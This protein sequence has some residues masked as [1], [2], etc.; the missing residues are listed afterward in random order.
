MTPENEI[1]KVFAELTSRYDKISFSTINDVLSG[2]IK[3]KGR[4]TEFAQ[5]KTNS[6]RIEEAE[7][8][9]LKYTCVIFTAF[10]GGYT[11][12]ENIA[13]NQQL[14][15]DM[16]E[17][18]LQYRPVTGCYREADWE[19]ANIE[20]CYFVYNEK[21]N[22]DLD[23]FIKAFQLSEKYDQDSFLYKRAGIN[24]T[25][26]L[27]ASTDAG[28]TDL[29]GNIRFAGQLFLYVPDVDAWTDCSDGRFSFQLKGMILIGTNCNKIKIGEGNLFDAESYGADGLVVLRRAN[30]DDLAEYCKN[31][32]GKA[33]L[34]QHVFKKD[35]PSEAYLH[36]VFTKCMKQIRDK[37]CKKIG[38]HCS[39]TMN[40][41]SIEGAS[42]VYDEI[43]S[44]VG[45]CNKKIDWI[46]V[47]DIYGEYSKV[48]NDRKQ[49]ETYQNNK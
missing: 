5:D 2:K 41:S 25:A 1:K 14:K 9:F 26:F 4:N 3:V 27:V 43:I 32:N 8:A 21:R 12:D 11:L 23:F 10:R 16:E 30:Q 47:V 49:K 24:R 38:F 18:G 35:N 7:A 36:D 6:P 13:R 19:Y 45:R 31:Y 29:K 34:V 48:L 28:R 39:V 44:W 22:N 15:A 40:D 37:K 20:Y 46:V 33:P 42:H 17:K